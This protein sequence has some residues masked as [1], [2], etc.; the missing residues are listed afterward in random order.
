M[1]GVACTTFNKTNLTANY[2][3]EI[4]HCILTTTFPFVA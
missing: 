4:P 2:F 3:D 1:A